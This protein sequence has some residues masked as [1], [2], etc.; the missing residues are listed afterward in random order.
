M[1][2]LIYACGLRRGELIELV[3]D[4]LE[5][6]R[7]LLRIRQSKGFRD[8]VVPI[9]EKVIQMIDIY[10][11]RYKPATYLYLR[12]SIGGTSIVQAVLTRYLKTRVK[13]QA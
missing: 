9:S 13:G 4:D 7:K 6:D 3:P 12:D 11:T 5:R 10:I 2:S 1:F 8:R